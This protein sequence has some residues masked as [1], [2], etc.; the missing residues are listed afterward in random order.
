MDKDLRHILIIVANFAA[1]G[2]AI[3]FFTKGCS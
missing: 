3:L 2:F 1:I